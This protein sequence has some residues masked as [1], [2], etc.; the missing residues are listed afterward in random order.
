[1]AISSLIEVLAP[2]APARGVLPALDHV[3]A[4]QTA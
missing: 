2:R 1:M 3:L 4:Q